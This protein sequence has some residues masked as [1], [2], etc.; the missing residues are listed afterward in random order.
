MRALPPAP[1]RRT[2]SARGLPD[3]PR[4]ARRRLRFICTL[5]TCTLLASAPA[6]A[7]QLRVTGTTWLRYIELRPLIRDS[8]AAVDVGGSGLLRVLPDGRSARCVP[9]EPYCRMTAQGART[10]S[11][12]LLHDLE[13]S[14]WGFGRGVRGYAQLRMRTALGN[15]AQLWPQADDASDLLVAYAELERSRYRIRAGRQWQLS[16]LGFYNFDG[17]NVGLEPAAGAW[18][19]SWVGRSLMRGMNETRAGGALA[20]IEELAPVAGGLLAGVHARYR[21]SPRLALGAAYQADFRTDGAGLWAELAAANI[22]LA[23]PAGDIDARLQLD[24]AAAALNEAG[25]RFR[26]I[27]VGSFVLHAGARRYRPYFELWTI[28]GA[29]SPVGFDELTGGATWRP[30]PRAPLL[31]AD[32]VYRSYGETAVEHAL[33]PFRGGGAGASLSASWA[34]AAKWRMDAALRAEGGFGAA[35]RDGHIGVMRRLGDMG[36]LAVQALAFERLY[37]FRLEEGIVYGLAGE[38]SLRL[39]SRAQLLAGAAAYHYPASAQAAGVDW[40]QRRGTLRFQWTAGSEPAPPLWR[41]GG[42][43]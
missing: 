5:V 25:I 29:F 2:M 28:W 40:N 34:P 11:I 18:L 38:L 37:E 32:A 9:D 24:V 43:P 1:N 22:S 16:G 39:S 14:A 26:S 12:P 4:P 23:S 17:I 35:R 7:Q 21:P 8:V 19:E 15:G 6:A 36:S 3:T 27:P 31:R 13:A 10:A 30:G 33:D 41:A 20:S 42:T